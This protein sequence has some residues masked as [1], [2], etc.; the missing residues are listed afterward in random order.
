LLRG[1]E[2]LDEARPGTLE[3]LASDRS[4]VLRKVAKVV[5]ERVG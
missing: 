4:Q 3:E 5:R 1:L 2:A